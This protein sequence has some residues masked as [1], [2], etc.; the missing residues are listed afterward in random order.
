MINLELYKIFVF[1]AK[2]CLLYTSKEINQAVANEI[3]KKIYG[4]ENI[5]EEI[6]SVKLL[7]ELKI[8]LLYTSYLNGLINI[9]RKKN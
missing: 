5:K 6:D 1:V 7:E 9:F 8:C 4:I 3:L 2:D